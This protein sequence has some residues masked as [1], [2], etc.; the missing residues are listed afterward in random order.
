M[1]VAERMKTLVLNVGSSSAKCWFRD[2]PDGELPSESMA[3]SWTAR[4]DWS[5]HPGTAEVRITRGDRVSVTRTITAETPSAFLAPIVESLWKGEATAV[6]APSAI[7]MVGHRIVHGGPKYRDSILVTPEVRAGIAAQAEFAPAHNR[8]QL[9]AI[10]TVDRVIGTRVP[11][12]AVFDTG[13][14]ATLQPAAYVYPGPYSWLEQGIRRYGFHGISVEY[15]TRRAA[16]LLNV[17]TN[18]SR[19]IVCHL[20]NGASV[21]AVANGQS[22][23]TSMGFTPLEG[24][25]MG[26]R[27][28]SI[29]PSILVYL[30]RRQHCSA[31]ELDQILNRKSGLL[32]VSGFS[33]DMREILEAIDKG[34]ERARLAFDVYAHRLTR[35]IGSM[36]AVLGGV[37]AII[38]TG[39]IGENCAPLRQIVC[40]QLAFTGLK[41]DAGKNAQPDLDQ[42]IA[43]A[44]SSVQVLVIRADEDWEIARQCAVLARSIPSTV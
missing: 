7:D 40:D 11:Q 18:S 27:S 28:G 43:A 33:S 41:L 25:M 30:I 6:D 16:E 8:L 5:R 21:T 26:S 22:V 34:N 1:E 13:F 24:I 23:D 37:D 15:S 31:D 10:E 35:E 44:G 14:H 39:G 36:L 4:A 38:F 3:P 29:D 2:V 42:N 9:A 32:G 12:V 20:G 19:L 17:P